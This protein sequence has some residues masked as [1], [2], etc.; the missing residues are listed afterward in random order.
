MLFPKLENQGVRLSQ[1]EPQKQE[2]LH[3]FLIISVTLQI[4]KYRRVCVQRKNFK[5]GGSA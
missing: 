4:F 3:S 2:I 5:I 1:H